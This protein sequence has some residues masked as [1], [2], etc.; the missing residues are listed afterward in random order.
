M[1]TKQIQR[2][3][4]Q[5]ILNHF[6]KMSD[7]SVTNVITVLNLRVVYIG[8]RLRNMK[9]LK[10]V[11]N[12]TML[13]VNRIYGNTGKETMLFLHSMYWVIRAIHI[14]MKERPIYVVC[15]IFTPGPRMWSRRDSR[16]S[17]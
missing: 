13:E 1:I 15:K 7:F 11:T 5:P 10:S 14:I 3:A 12:V 4:L 6:I 2:K 16:R 9:F 8:I 17:T